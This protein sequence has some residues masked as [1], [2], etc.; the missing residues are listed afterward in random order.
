MSTGLETRR[1]PGPRHRPWRRIGRGHPQPSFLDA[2]SN[3]PDRFHV[4][5][6]GHF[7]VADSTWADPNQSNLHWS[8]RRRHHESGGVR[9]P[10]G[11]SRRR[12]PRASRVSRRAAHHLGSSGTEVFVE[13]QG[14]GRVGRVPPTAQSFS[15]TAV[16]GISP[17]RMGQA[18]PT[19][20]VSK[21]LDEGIHGWEPGASRSSTYGDSRTV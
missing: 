7:G 4:G 21:L 5:W 14:G 18:Q 17:V 8:P 1:P 2:D 19:M 10:P 16:E 6:A 12:D 9:P 11:R 15:V 20:P 13:V 3:G